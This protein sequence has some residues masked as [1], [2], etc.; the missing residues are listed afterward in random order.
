MYT[1]RK[2][3]DIPSHAFMTQGELEE[4]AEASVQLQMVSA[5]EI[6]KI[7]FFQCRIDHCYSYT[8]T[9]TYNFFFIILATDSTDTICSCSE[10]VDEL[11]RHTFGHEC[12]E[13]YVSTI[14]MCAYMS[15]AHSA[16]KNKIFF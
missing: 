16:L 2:S 14:A 15:I 1:Y 12:M 13:H 3:V 6:M 8:Y 5:T 9:Y 10:A 4:P 11:L 7:S